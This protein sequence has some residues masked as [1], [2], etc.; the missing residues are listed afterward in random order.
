MK[1]LKRIHTRTHQPTN[2][3]MVYLY[4]R[5]E[6]TELLWKISEILPMCEESFPPTKEFLMKVMDVLIEFVK[7]TNDRNEK[8]II[9]YR[10]MKNMF[11][12]LFFTKFWFV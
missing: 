11:Y 7:N 2:I 1:H 5:S 9:V 8:V 6:K 10:Q 12:I 3:Y 4:K